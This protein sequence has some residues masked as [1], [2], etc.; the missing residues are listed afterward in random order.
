[1]MKIS[2]FRK[3]LDIYG[4]DLSRWPRHEV[5][6]AIDLIQRDPESGKAFAGAERLDQM[7]RRYPAASVNTKAL[8]DKIVRSAKRG[9]MPAKAR[10]IDPTHLFLPG[11]GL[12]VAAVLGFM[13]GFHT[14]PANKES[15][16]LDSV[17]YTQDHIVDS[18][19]A[20]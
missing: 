15:L 13:M 11:G 8:A 4:A 6:A 10:T 12:I 19:E 5:R 16:M 18:E 7:L 14:V 17:L 9:V 1:M 3:Y 2:D 20:S